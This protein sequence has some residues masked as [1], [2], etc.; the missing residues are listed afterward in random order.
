MDLILSLFKDDTYL[1]MANQVSPPEDREHET[2][3]FLSHL[4]D[5]SIQAQ[6]LSKFTNIMFIWR[7][8]RISYFEFS[9]EF[10]KEEK[11]VK[12]TEVETMLNMVIAGFLKPDFPY[13]SQNCFPLRYVIMFTECTL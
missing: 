5:Q 6:L 8:R 12:Q 4:R 13:P 3:A 11:S 9:V 1:R 10:V 2:Q 7:V